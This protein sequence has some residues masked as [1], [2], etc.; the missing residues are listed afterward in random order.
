MA[1]PVCCWAFG[2][3][4]GLP[5]PIP[6]LFSVASVFFLFDWSFTIYGGNVASTMAGEFSFSIALC[7]AMLYLGVLAHGM[8]TGKGRALAAFPLRADR[9]LPPDRGHL[10]DRRDRPSLSALG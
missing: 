1:F 6:P 4:A 5:F 9:A 3:L 10:R 7:L 2:R 8:R